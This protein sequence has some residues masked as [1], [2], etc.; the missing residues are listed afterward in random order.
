PGIIDFEGYVICPDCSIHLNCTKVGLANLIEWHMGSERCKVNRA[1]QPRNKTLK[2]NGSLLTFFTKLK[3]TPV[4]LTVAS[5]TVLNNTVS[6]SSITPA[7]FPSEIKTYHLR[8]PEDP[9]NGNFLDRLFDSISRLLDSIP[10]ASVYDTLAIFSGSPADY[11][12]SSIDV[13]DLWEMILN[14]LLK[15]V[16]GWGIE[17]DMDNL[18]CHGGMGLDGLAN[19]V[20]HFVVKWGVDVALFEGKP[21]HLLQKIEEK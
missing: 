17:K 1:I 4:P 10:V 11:N 16:I 14:G 8:M 7:L 12:N 19:F 9:H 3:P 6:P 5:L 15:S 13:A 21:S 18:I 2:K 20:R